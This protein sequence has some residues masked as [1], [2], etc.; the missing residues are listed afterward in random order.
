MS[1]RWKAPYFNY[2]IPLLGEDIAYYKSVSSIP[3]LCDRL[4]QAFK[5]SG[6]TQSLHFK[7][8]SSDTIGFREKIFEL[9]L[10]NYTPLMHGRI[11]FDSAN[12]V[13]RVTGFSN[14]FPIVFL[15]FWYG[16]LFPSIDLRMDFVFLMAPI[17]LFGAIYYFQRKKYLKVMDYLREDLGV[18][19]TSHSS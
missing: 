9:S 19:P 10:F 6:Y 13:G 18:Y 14:W 11:L 5:S 7:D 3:D 12:R 15:T 8:L 4:N 17:I 16:T 1:G 2:G